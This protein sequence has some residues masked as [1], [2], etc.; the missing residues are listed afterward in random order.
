MFCFRHDHSL[1]H[2]NTEHLLGLSESLSAEPRRIA[3]NVATAAVGD[4]AD[5]Y[6][7]VVGSLYVKGRAHRSQ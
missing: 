4:S 7:S 6:A 3:G 2:I 5:Y 1:W